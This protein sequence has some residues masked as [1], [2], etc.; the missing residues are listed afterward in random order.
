M[1]YNILWGMI[2]SIVAVLASPSATSLD[3]KVFDSSINENS[4]PHKN[5]PSSYEL[6]DS[7]LYASSVTNDNGH[8]TFIIILSVILLIWYFMIIFISLIGV[9]VIRFQN[10]MSHPP[11]PF[12]IQSNEQ[13]HTSNNFTSTN[14]DRIRIEDNTIEDVE[15]VTILR[16][17]KGIDTEMK[18]CLV[19]AFLQQYPKFEIIFCVESPHDPAIPIVQSLIERYSHIDASLLIDE[20]NDTSQ[21]YGPNPKINNLAKGYF[22]AKYDMIW[23]LDSNVWVSAGTLARSVDAFKAP[24][25]G[26][27]KIKLVHHLPM[28]V[29][30]E[31]SFR[32]S[33]GSKL[34]EM[35]MLT[36][37]SKFY[38][39]INT[40]AI[41]PCVTGKSNLYRRS[42]LDAAVANKLAEHHQKLIKSK[43]QK[44]QPDNGNNLY[45]G[46]ITNP[47][48]NIFQ[49]NIHKI[50]KPSPPWS[51]SSS[52]TSLNQ[53]PLQNENDTDILISDGSNSN[54]NSNSGRSSSGSSSSKSSNNGSDSDYN[55]L[56]DPML[57]SS[58]PSLSNTDS[59]YSTEVVPGT[60]IR[61]FAQYI[62]EDNMIALCLWEN[63]NGRTRLTSD[64]VIQPLADVSFKGYWDRRVRWLR[65]RRYMVSAAT[66]VEP[67]TESICSGI[68]GT[69]AI[70][71]LFLS[72][73]NSEKYS[74]RFWSWTWFIFHMI[75]WIIVDY[76][77]FHN[78]L[79]FENVDSINRPYFVAKYFSPK[80]G[81]LTCRRRSLKYW[82][83]TWLFREILAFPIWLTAM[84]GHRIYW[85]DRP[86]R[87][88]H[89]LS[90][91]EITD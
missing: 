49:R 54:G 9:V 32:T 50:S 33:W 6:N 35:F 25:R 58:T 22:K 67:T 59:D 84:C 40:V 17:I 87:I 76:Y 7:K 75:C 36:S 42:D 79:A 39:A 41:A 15:G 65:V 88:L 77:H 13:N 8:G 3:A 11:L 31:P 66:Y 91:E 37:H 30:L 71:V 74:L 69:F 38:T 72:D 80:N 81:A 47:D 12:K 82:L 52:S 61:N 45:S 2:G 78:L 19:S 90:T 34:D 44:Y 5:D 24:G 56:N 53:Y 55:N 16:P 60:G 62:A 14:S 4:I 85:R 27:R 89:D 63:G 21:H 28:C 20:E 70:S 83:P 29:S 57:L 68:F 26:G 10:A 46:R 1:N 86:F 18:Y 43:Y 23:V 73:G 64:S 51:G 48:D